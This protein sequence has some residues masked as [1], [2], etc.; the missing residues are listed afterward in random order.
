MTRAQR[1]RKY[2]VSSLLGMPAAM[3]THAL[4][5]GGSHVAGGSAHGFA[6][7]IAALCGAVALGIGVNAARRGSRASMPSIGTVALV[8]AAWFAALEAMEP[9]HSVP[10]ALCLL[11]LAVVAAVLAWSARACTHAVALLASSFLRHAAQDEVSSCAFA[12]RLGVVR[13]TH[14]RF[15]RFSRP[16]PALS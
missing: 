3:L 11:V 14:R 6:L 10:V 5:F 8:A 2:A 13:P 15:E 7:A 16:P 4:V 1:I 9:R 12:L